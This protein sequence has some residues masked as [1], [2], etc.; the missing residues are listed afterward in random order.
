MVGNPTACLDGCGYYS[1]AVKSPNGDVGVDA[2]TSVV[3]HE[4]VEAVSDPESDGNRAWEDG[5]G[6]ENADKCAVS[7]CI[8]FLRIMLLMAE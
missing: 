5:T 2:M 1:N 4:L 3:A 8:F 7:F 6:Y